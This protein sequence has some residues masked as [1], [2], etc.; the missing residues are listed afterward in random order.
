MNLYRYHKRYDEKIINHS[1]IHI[2]GIYRF[3]KKHISKAHAL[4]HK[5]LFLLNN[6]GCHIFQAKKDH[7]RL[8]NFEGEN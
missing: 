1:V 4:S 6:A 3:M 8:S 5:F 2:L 7:F